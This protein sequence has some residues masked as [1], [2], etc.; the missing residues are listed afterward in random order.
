MLSSSGAGGLEIVH[1]GSCDPW[2]LHHVFQETGPGFTRAA[3]Q[4]RLQYATLPDTHWRSQLSAAPS[5]R[6]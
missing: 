4:P 6:A 3:P 5:K 2:Q 1:K